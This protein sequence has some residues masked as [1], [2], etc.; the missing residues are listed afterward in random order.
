M[1]IQ[2]RISFNDLSVRN[3]QCENH[4]LLKYYTYIRVVFLSASTPLVQLHLVLGYNNFNVTIFFAGHT[5][6]RTITTMVKAGDGGGTEVRE[7]EESEDTTAE[8]TLKSQ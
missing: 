5:V 4:L 1:L 2:Q 7:I 3:D 8:Q 6:G